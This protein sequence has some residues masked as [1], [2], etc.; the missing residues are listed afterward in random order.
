[1]CKVFGSIHMIESR[2]FSRV[3]AVVIIDKYTSASNFFYVHE[4]NAIIKR[5]SAISRAFFSSI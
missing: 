5:R 1:M 4:V 3:Y 2:T